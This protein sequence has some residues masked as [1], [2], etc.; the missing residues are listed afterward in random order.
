[1]PSPAAAAAAEPAG[2]VNDAAASPP[3]PRLAI[4]GCGCA[5]LSAAYLA[6][7]AGAHV[8]LYESGSKLG[9]HAN[10]VEVRGRR[11]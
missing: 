7:K 9:G 4:V 8:T 1:M 5:G 6:S 3:T 10:T 2:P 11:G